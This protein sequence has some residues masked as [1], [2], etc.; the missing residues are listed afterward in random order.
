MTQNTPLAALLLVVAAFRQTLVA[1]SPVNVNNLC[2]PS[3]TRNLTVEELFNF[4]QLTNHFLT[5]EDMDGASSFVMAQVWI[6][7]QTINV[8]VTS[9]PSK[10]FVIDDAMASTSPFRVD[11]CWTVSLEVSAKDTGALPS[12]W[13]SPESAAG[14]VV[15]L[16]L[17]MDPDFFVPPIPGFAEG[18]KVVIT[19]TT[20]HG[21]EITKTTTTTT[22][23][24]KRKWTWLWT[25]AAALTLGSLTILM[26]YVVYL[27]PSPLRY[28][29][30]NDSQDG[31]A[32]KGWP[33]HGESNVELEDESSCF[34]FC[35]S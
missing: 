28:L 22:V 29:R 2:F 8:T 34:S 16:R 32:N 23:L 26:V 11:K 7:F 24:K 19:T 27:R 1:S 17:G 12:I 9:N 4:E 31:T 13:M 18:G 10:W 20:Q 33:D 30:K 25:T 15:L 5:S 21:D 14:Y 35:T 6:P 3:V